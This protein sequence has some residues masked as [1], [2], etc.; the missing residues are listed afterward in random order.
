MR[1]AC[2]SIFQKPQAGSKMIQKF[3]FT[4]APIDSD[5]VLRYVLSFN[6]RPK[7]AARV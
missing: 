6:L 5:A 7:T 3:N 4:V 2:A 1:A